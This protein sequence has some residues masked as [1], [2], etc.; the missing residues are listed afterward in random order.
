MKASI[1]Y[2]AHMYT[3]AYACVCMHIDLVVFELI[4]IRCFILNRMRIVAVYFERNE[5]K[6]S[7]L[8]WHLIDSGHIAQCCC[9][10]IVPSNQT[11]YLL[12]MCRLTKVTCASGVLDLISF[13]FMI[14][15][16]ISSSL[17][18]DFF[19]PFPHSYTWSSH[20]TTN[21]K[22]MLEAKSKVISVVITVCHNRLNGVGCDQK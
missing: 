5:W 17:H 1:R 9:H 12:D 7:P 21:N 16:S 8:W 11:R 13:H 3:H 20:Q 19:L 15:I 14:R 22:M 6:N 18:S 2:P 10:D 4:W